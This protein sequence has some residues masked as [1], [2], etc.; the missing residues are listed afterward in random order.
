MLGMCVDMFGYVWRCVDMFVNLFGCV[1]I[2]L[3]ICLDVLDMFLNVLD[4]FAPK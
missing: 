2:C 1:W 3:L 4:L